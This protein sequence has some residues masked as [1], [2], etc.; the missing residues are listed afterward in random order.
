MGAE[1]KFTYTNV[2][3]P[4]PF[5]SVNSNVQNMPNGYS[6]TIRLYDQVGGGQPLDFSHN[7]ITNNYIQDPTKKLS[8]F[9]EN[10]EI[11]ISLIDPLYENYK[12]GAI[13]FDLYDQFN[14]FID[15]NNN[16]NKITLVIPNYE[17]LPGNSYY[18]IQPTSGLS[19][20]NY[21][22]I[23]QAPLTIAIIES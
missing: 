9:V 3:N 8:L 17:I 10:N 22:S 15:A 5:N 13:I 6:G 16:M 14:N 11:K 18:L 20:D 4:T 7:E 21:Q 2:C 1:N 12:I 19:P 23:I